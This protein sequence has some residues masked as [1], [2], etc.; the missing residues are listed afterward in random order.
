M[1]KVRWIAGISVP[2]W[3]TFSGGTR[4]RPHGRRGPD[5]DE[6]GMR[7]MRGHVLASAAF[8]AV[9]ALAAAPAIAQSNVQTKQYDSGDVYEGEFKDGRQH[10]QGTFRRPDGFQYTGEWVEGRIEGAG[11]ATYPNGSVYE[12][13]FLDGAPH[14]FGKITYADG[15]S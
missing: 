13:A 9:A 14:G 4:P 11:V 5:R 10:G 2:A 7:D 1:P 6:N 12:G 8:A 15:G 3:E